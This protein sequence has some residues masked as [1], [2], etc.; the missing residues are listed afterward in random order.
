MEDSGKLQKDGK[1]TLRIKKQD[2]RAIVDFDQHVRE[3]NGVPI[4]SPEG[5]LLL[6]VILDGKLSV[7]SG[8]SVA[9]T[10]QGTYFA[11]LRRLKK[12]GLIKAVPDASD[13]RVKMLQLGRE[14]T[15]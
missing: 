4:L 13:G 9:A 11:I 7:G 10:S 1:I 8:Q 15:E 14:T 6:S 3:A 2:L 5:R 12:A